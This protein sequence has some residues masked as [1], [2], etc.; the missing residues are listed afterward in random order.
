MLISWV[1]LTSTVGIFL[2][3]S[4]SGMMA[5]PDWSLAILVGALLHHR[6]TWFWVLPYVLFHDVVLYW[7]PWITFPYVLLTAGLLFYAD[8]R[9]APGQ[10]Q[11]WFGLL[12]CCTPL[13][14]AGVAVWT[15]L[16]TL[17]LSVGVWSLLSSER[18]KV[19]VESA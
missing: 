14:F 17:T 16:L 7:S 4:F 2:N 19:Y 3:L 10:P 12:L 18:E 6:Q 11:R 5:Q 1:L 8:Y 15:W 9:L 13:L